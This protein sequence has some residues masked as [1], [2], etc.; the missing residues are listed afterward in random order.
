MRFLHNILAKAGLIVD[1]VTQLNTI[2]NATI[3]TDKFL[4]SD[5]GVIK[6]RTGAELGSDIGAANLA[7]STL[8]HQVKLGEAINKGQA[9]YVSSADGTNMIVSKASNASEA[10]SSKTL[11]LIETSGVLND[12]VNVVTE[13]LLAGLDTSTAAAGDPVWL[14]TGGNLI[15]GL[16]NKPY[17]PAHLVFIGIVTRVH[18]NNGEIFVKVQNGFELKEIHD[19][20][21]TTTPSNNTVLAYESATSLYKMKSIA[22]LL[23]YTP[24]DDSLVVHL[25]GT[26]TITGAKTFSSALTLST[27]ANATIDTDRFLVSDSGVVKY[28]TGAEVLSDIGAQPLLTN[29]VTG[30]GTTNYLAKFTSSSA[31][32]NS[33][34]FDN[35]TNVGI[36]TTSPVTKLDVNGAGVIR[37]FLT[38]TDAIKLGGNTSAPTSTDAFIYRPADNT[39]AFGTASA[40]RMRLDVSG[41]LL[42]GL[43]S[44]LAN[45]KLQVAGSI[46]L[47][48]NTQIRQA[49][50]SDGNTLQVFATQ[51]IAGNL[52]SY[53]YGYSGGGLLASVSAGDSILL[54]DAGRTTS[55]EG[56]VK[57]TNTTLGNVSFSVEKNGVT[58]LF[59]STLGNVGIGSANPQVKLD[60]QSGS[61]GAYHNTASSG[62]AQ[63]YLGDM[64]FAGG[65]YA[66]SAPGVGA[67]YGPTHLVAGDLAFYV[68]NGVASSRSEAMR[69]IRHSSG[70]NYVGIGTTTPTT[71]LHVLS[72]DNTYANLV[73]AAT[74][75]N[76][77]VTG[78]LTFG[79]L[80]NSDALNFYTGASSTTKMY[81]SNAGNVGIGTTS[82]TAKLHL[83]GGIALI[84]NTIG[85][86]A[87]LYNTS[88]L[89]MYMTFADQG[90]SS[91]IGT[92]NGNLVFYNNTNTTERMR[93]T[94]GGNVGIGTTSPGTRLVV[95]QSADN[96]IGFSVTNPTGRA[97]VF[98]YSSTFQL[99]IGSSTNDNIRYGNFGVGSGVLSFLNNGSEAMRITSGGDLLVGTTSGT[100]RIQAVGKAN[101]WVT[102]LQA[103]TTSGQS[104]GLVIRAGTS[105]GDFPFYVLSA[106]NST[107]FMAIKGNGN[108]GIGTTSPSYKLEVN[109]GAGN[110]G[111][112]ARFNAP[113]YDEVNISAG[114]SNWIGT[115]STSSFSLRSNN[116]D[117]L[118]VHGTTGNVLIGTTT[119][120]G[121]K[122]DVSGTARITSNLLAQKVQVGTAATINDAAGVA[123]TLQFANYTL[124]TFITGSAD[125]YIYK[126]SN[127]IGT[128]S[129]QTLIFQTRS[130]VAGGGFAFVSGATPSV[131]A[132]ISSNGAVRFNAYGSGS[133]TGTRAY[134]LSVDASGNIIEVPV[135]AGTITG[136]G[137]TNYIPKF[138]SSSAIGN[139]IVQ[140]DGTNV[141]VG[142]S[143]SSQKLRIYGGTIISNNNSYYGFT[144]L[145]AQASIAGITSGDNITLGQNNV[146]HSNTII[147]GGTG[148]IQFSTGGSERMRLDASGNLLVGGSSGDGKLYVQTSSA[149]AYSSIDYNGTNANLRLKSGGSPTTNTTAGI[150]FG[151]GGLAE[152]YVGAVQQANT[153]ANL[154]FQTFGP[155]AV[156]STKMTLDASGN[157]GLGVTPS[158]WYNAGNYVALQVGNASLY[159]RN[160]SN[161]EAYLSSNSFYITGT[162]L[163]TYI[164][165]NFATEYRQINGV[166]SWHN[167]P[168]GT[169]N[170]SISFTQA[171]TLDASGNFMVGGTSS[172]N[173]RAH[174]SGLGATTGTGTGSSNIVMLLTDTN[175][176]AQNV[177]AGIG[178]A[179]NDGVN[180]GVTFATIN[181]RKENSTMGNYA[182][183]LSFQTRQSGDVLTERMRITSSGDLYV[184]GTTDSYSE[185]NRR[186]LSL[187][188]GTNALISFRASGSALGYIYA[189]S[190]ALD[191]AAVNRSITFSAG[192]GPA[193][194]MRITSSGDVGIGTTSPQDKLTVKGATNYNLNIGL[195]G[196]KSGIYVYNDASSAYNDLRIDASTLLLNSYSGAN[197]AIAASSAITR[198]TIGA[199]SGQRLPYINGTGNTF[200]ANGI[201]VT[202]SN[203]ANASIGGGLDL[204]NNVHSIGSFSPLISFS[205]LSQSGI[206]NN[207]YAAIYG[208]LA[209]D[210]GDGNWNSGHLVFATAFAYGTSEKMRITN[211]GN[212][213]IGTTT[214]GGYKLDVSGT[215]RNTLSTSTDVAQQ[216]SR[217]GALNSSGQ[218]KVLDIYYTGSSNLI[219]LRTQA[220]GTDPIIGLQI[221]SSNPTMYVNSSSVGIGGTPNAS[222]KLQVESTTQGFL[223]P[224]MTQ[225]QRDAITTPA[226]GLII[227]Q[228]DNNA[229]FYFYNGTA[230]KALAIVQ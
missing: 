27:V 99:D 25:A 117:R 61:I 92:N 113:S 121:Y 189:Y 104:Y 138:T 88:G 82:P 106:D 175:S 19:V 195:L 170:T 59:A 66:T 173:V 9:V 47:S 22:T 162:G 42:I 58:T 221:G 210:S 24:A 176:G 43:S 183:Y 226:T 38:T 160:S 185:A 122:L 159:G 194:R 63:L 7:A 87:T 49:T 125:N 144:S 181:G 124:G 192:V 32:G 188:G 214:D 95:Q 146:N 168:S 193:E 2:A 128:L 62:G 78:G 48:G 6:Y 177:G 85:Y 23:G 134:D 3:D 96:A 127:V 148:T 114:L 13:G 163:A 73:I 93:I 225:T 45:G 60:V 230:W 30:T 209:G 217:F 31:V 201:T 186:V 54:F 180:T 86:G 14:G 81:I 220:V 198:L 158:A 154:V 91:G 12:Q 187:N 109:L 111:I 166:H 161:S 190:T 67:V 41:N 80:Y 222:A 44:A 224:R 35:G 116:T 123:N 135:G 103:S 120:A 1:G 11:G 119:D 89:G 20:Q 142:G 219:T 17:A 69:I 227:F 126:T 152:I 171:M 102:D 139:S 34:L 115:N 197:V 130:D 143:P 108:V 223:P 211:S 84:E 39:L 208:I 107:A 149:V 65:A 18:Q 40:E 29:P 167:A 156:Y 74:S 26:E 206:Y 83:T 218:L 203:T 76:G 37:G 179:G 28:R 147:Y 16:A 71:K 145:G 112:I 100:S 50:N 172:N 105:S 182:S 57:I 97:S 53:S 15:F 150:S 153:Y 56:R 72:S 64:N 137:T 202:S 228:T 229:G 141:G 79:G 207:N 151:V 94:T 5:G 46:G 196:S 204:T 174:I 101:E 118:T 90:N 21:I 199:Y 129:A 133:F 55:T 68:Y 77:N 110:S 212:V 75:N 216:V 191:I 164:T 52:N 213:L 10:T 4:V 140:D 132:N 184:G 155:G 169:A 200:N 8:K 131:I 98:G 136:S 215:F 178:F 36:G 157:L 205:S 33:Q 70:N 165:S 51:V